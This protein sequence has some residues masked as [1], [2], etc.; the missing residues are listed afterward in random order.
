MNKCVYG[1]EPIH[2]TIGF[3]SH[4]CVTTTIVYIGEQLISGSMS[5]DW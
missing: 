2:A 5:R 4:T 1:P 3:T